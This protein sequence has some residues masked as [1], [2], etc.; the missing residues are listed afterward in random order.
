LQHSKNAKSK[1]YLCALRTITVSDI[2]YI[3]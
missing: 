3:T 1:Q 2:R